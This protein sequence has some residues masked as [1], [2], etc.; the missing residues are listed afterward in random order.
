[1]KNGLGLVIIIFII[2]V[3]YFIYI[4]LPYRF[5][6]IDYLE[7]VDI[8]SSEGIIYIS[9]NEEYSKVTDDIIKKLLKGSKIKVN[10]L[11]IDKVDDITFSN[12]M[13]SLEL[14]KD[15]INAPSILYFKDGIL[16]DYIEGIFTLD[17]LVEFIH[18]NGIEG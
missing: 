11:S 4:N 5:N 7:Y 14:T 12:I 6:E 10:R 2:L 17:D 18:K 13:S 8:I 9:N 1:M 3:S 15:G 16:V